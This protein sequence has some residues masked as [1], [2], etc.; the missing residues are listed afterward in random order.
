MRAHERAVLEHF[1]WCS[2]Q[3]IQVAVAVPGSGAPV[4]HHFPAVSLLLF[5]AKQWFAA[6]PAYRLLARKQVR[7]W[8]RGDILP[9]GRARTPTRPRHGDPAPLPFTTCTQLPGDI[10]FMPAEWGHAVLNHKAGVAVA[11]E[12]LRDSAPRGYLAPPQP[13]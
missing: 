13:V 7:R 4:H 6:P 8:A 12:L 9:S 5:G 1:V 10:V 2:A 11:T 3:N